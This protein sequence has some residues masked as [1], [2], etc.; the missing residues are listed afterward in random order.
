MKNIL[1]CL[2]GMVILVIIS[3]SARAASSVEVQLG[4]KQSTVYPF[5]WG[6]TCNNVGCTTKEGKFFQYPALVSI[7]PNSYD[8]TTRQDYFCRAGLCFDQTLSPIGVDSTYL[9]E[10]DALV[11]YGI[12]SMGGSGNRTMINIGDCSGL[13]CYV[14]KDP[15]K[16]VPIKLLMNQVPTLYDDADKYDCTVGICVDKK[17]GWVV[18]VD[19][20]DRADLIK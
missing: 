9:P 14:D 3:Q 10:E 4:T 2:I 13:F 12:K 11:G 16:R 15:D 17:T 5:S 19:A 18:G 8:Y 20:E 7:F 1:A 6:M